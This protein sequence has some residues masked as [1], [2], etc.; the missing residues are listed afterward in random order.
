ML[1][2]VSVGDYTPLE[3]GR[4]IGVSDTVPVAFVRA[5]RLDEAE[6]KR[7][8]HLACTANN[9]PVAAH[10]EP[11]NRRSSGCSTESP[12]RPLACGT[13]APSCSPGTRSGERSTPLPSPCGS[14]PAA[15]ARG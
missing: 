5:L 14:H 7:P 3:R 6:R 8:F 4:R 2:G 13:S 9:S 12:R 11:C 1:A 10:A 15:H